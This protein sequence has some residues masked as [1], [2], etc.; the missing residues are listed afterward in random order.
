MRLIILQRG[1]GQIMSTISKKTN[2]RRYIP[3]HQTGKVF[4]RGRD[5]SVNARLTRPTRPTSTKLEFS[6]EP[7]AYTFWVTTS[8]KFFEIID[9]I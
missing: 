4:R 5:D 2:F 3:H 1:R 8:E 9:M 6:T 7:G